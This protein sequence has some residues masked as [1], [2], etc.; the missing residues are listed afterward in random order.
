MK[1]TFEDMPPLGPGEMPW[2]DHEVQLRAAL[3]AAEE[4]PPA[5]LEQRIWNALDTKTTQPSGPNRAP[6]IAAAVAGVALLGASWMAWEDARSH[7]PELPQLQEI[8]VVENDAPQSSLG[9]ELAGEHAMDIVKQEGNESMPEWMPPSSQSDELGNA[10]TMRPVSE[11]LEVMKELESSPIP[12]QNHLNRT[13]M[14][15]AQVAGDTVRMQGSLK[16]KQ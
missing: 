12:S 5:G 14:Q 8:N 13:P 6:W 7:V 2:S 3:N 10:T 4:T 15:P 11:G 16:L 1:A 9:H